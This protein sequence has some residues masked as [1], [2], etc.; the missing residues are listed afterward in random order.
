MFKDSSPQDSSIN[1]EKY[2]LSVTCFIRTFVDNVAPTIT[3]RIYPNQKPWMKGEIHT[4]L[5]VRTVAFLVSRM[6]PDDSVARDVYNVS[7]SIKDA[8]R[9]YK[10]NKLNQC[11]T[12]QTDDTYG[13][14][15]QA[16]TKVNP[17]VWC[18]PKPPF[19]TSLT[20]SVPALRQ[21][22]PSHPGKLSLLR[23][24]FCPRLM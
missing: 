16:I 11:S 12:T 3:I 19:Q 9:Q 13:Q 6:N 7:K 10:L 4:M 24:N 2:T 23:V 8:K 5:R 21:T 18:P 15:T 22:I 14:I 17:G 20:H 1:I